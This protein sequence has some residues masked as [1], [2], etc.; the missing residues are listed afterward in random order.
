[1]AAE[2]VEEEA[3]HVDLVNR[4]LRRY[5]PPRDSWADDLDPPA[6]QE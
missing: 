6:S 5:P 4:L 1:M 3:E 2:L